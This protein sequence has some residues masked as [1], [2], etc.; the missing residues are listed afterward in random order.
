MAEKAGFK[1]FMLKEIYEQPR[2]IRDTLL[3]RISQETGQIFLDEM[4]ITDEEF[5]ACQKLHLVACG[6]SW[7]AALVGKF[8]IERLARLPVEVDIA[9]EF[10]HRTPTLEKNHLVAAISHARA[11]TT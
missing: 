1:H 7:H 6:T 8:M 10:R 11:A 5:R 3:G 4:E 9:S 2:A